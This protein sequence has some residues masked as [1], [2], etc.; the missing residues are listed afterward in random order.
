[1]IVLTLCLP[2]AHAGV[3]DLS[4]PQAGP[5]PSVVDLSGG[6][7]DAMASFE[8]KTADRRPRR[9]AMPAESHCG[10]CKV[11]VRM[12]EEPQPTF[13]LLLPDCDR[14]PRRMFL[15]GSQ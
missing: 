8:A 3:L 1:V 7:Q 9:R 5:F 15:E 13:G 4:T 12:S 6:A 10:A 11:V 14:F 2:T